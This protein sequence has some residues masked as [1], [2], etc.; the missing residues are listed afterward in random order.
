MTRSLVL[1]LALLGAGCTLTSDL[2]S[3]GLVADFQLTDET[4]Q[5][6]SSKDRLAGRIWIANFIFTTCQ[7]PC[8][9]MTAQMRRVQEGLLGVDAIRLVSFTIDPKNDTP[10]VLAAYAKRFQA[11]PGKWH[12]LTGTQAAL[13]H[14]SHDSMMLGSVN[15]ALEH[16]TRFVLVDRRGRI[17]GYYQSDEPGA[18]DRVIA[19]ARKLLTERL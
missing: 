11:Q 6:F 17:R 19:D 16:S 12:F 3:Y 9:R 13:H 8:P 4:G 7:G 15:G 5:P 14:I 2:P 1:A 10:A 18:I